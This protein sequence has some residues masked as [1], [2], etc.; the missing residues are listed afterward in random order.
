MLKKKFTSQSWIKQTFTLTLYK[1]KLQSQLNVTVKGIIH[2]YVHI[3]DKFTYLC[4]KQS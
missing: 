3:I 1:K 4:G 2:T